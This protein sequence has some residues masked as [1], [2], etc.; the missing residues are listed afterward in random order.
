MIP[1]AVRIFVCLEPVDMRYSFDRLA[2]T[3]TSS[4]LR[5]AAAQ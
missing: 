3:V 2:A 1:A 4:G 5:A